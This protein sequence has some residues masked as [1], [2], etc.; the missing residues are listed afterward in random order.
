MRPCIPIRATNPPIGE[1][2]HEPKL[3]GYRT[4]IVKDGRQVRL[5]SRRGNEWTERLATLAEAL[6]HIPC[7]SAVLDAELCLLAGDGVPSFAGLQAAFSSRRRDELVVYA[8]D[9]LHRD[10]ADLRRLP[11]TERRRRLERLMARGY[12]HR[13]PESNSGLHSNPGV[14]LR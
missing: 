1:W 6:A 5:Y 9:L 4:Q 8:F 12:L 11:L 14:F 13:R 7:R 10:G 3:D 2:L